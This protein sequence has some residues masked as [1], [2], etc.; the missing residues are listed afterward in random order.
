MTTNGGFS[1]LR[2]NAQSCNLCLYSSHTHAYSAANWSFQVF[3]SIIQ[4]KRFILI[5]S[6]LLILLPL[7]AQENST[8]TEDAQYGGCLPTPKEEYEAIPK[9]DWATI[10]LTPRAAHPSR[11][12][13]NH[14]PIGNQGREGSCTAW[15]LGYC[16]VGVLGY[17]RLKDD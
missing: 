5:I 4:M 6:F 10:G 3:N 1:P 11:M 12:I 13:L 17:E 16:A 9:V 7:M 15:A 14:P 8:S 2:R